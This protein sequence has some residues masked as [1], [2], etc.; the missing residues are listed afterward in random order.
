MADTK[1]HHA[2]SPLKVE[3]DGVSYSGIFWFVVVLTV[4][5]VACQLLVVGLFAYLDHRSPANAS[6]RSP[7]ASPAGQLPPPPNLLRDEP[8]N[9][10]TFS[11]DE[12]TALTKYGW[13]DQATGIVR[14]PI[15]RAKDLIIERGLPVRGAAAPVPEAT[16]GK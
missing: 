1:H 2:P 4:T 11:D 3:G 8:A 14:L 10:K 12:H 6:P 16:K 15:D 9:L 13:V 5:T 7:L